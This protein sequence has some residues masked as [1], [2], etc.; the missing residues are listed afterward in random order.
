MSNNE[1][2]EILNKYIESILPHILTLQNDIAENPYG[3]IEGKPL[4]NQVLLDFIKQ[5]E[6]LETEA[7]AL[8]NQA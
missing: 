7:R 3:D 2:L 6:A 8:T 1:K 5:K 4:R